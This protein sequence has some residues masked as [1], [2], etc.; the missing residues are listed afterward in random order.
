VNEKVK[1]ATLLSDKTKLLQELDNER[2]KNAKLLSDQAKLSQALENEQSKIAMLMCDKANLAQELENTKKSISSSSSSSSLHHQPLDTKMVSSTGRKAVIVKSSDY[3]K[4]PDN[5]CAWID[6]KTFYVGK[7][8][9]YNRGQLNKP[10]DWQCSKCN[11]Q[12]QITVT[13]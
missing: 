9:E 8:G 7:W 11:Q 2:S 1:V 3:Y 4:C 12:F 13:S 6:V 10:F 5:S